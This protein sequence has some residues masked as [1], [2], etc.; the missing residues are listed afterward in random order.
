[1][2][3]AGIVVIGNEVL[4]GK[5]DEENARYL[6][7]ELR[8]LGVKLMRV[9]IVRDEVETIA[10]E[11]QLQASRFTHVFT[12]GGVGGTHDDVT[13]EGVAHAFG[14]P[15]VRNR[16]LER[17]IVAH[18]K[19]RANEMVLRM[20]DLP[21]GA[22]LFGLGTLVYPAVRVRNVFVFPGVPSYF[23][24]K[25]EHVKPM[26]KATPIFLRQILVNVGE[27]QIAEAMIEVQRELAAIEIGSYPR[28]DAAEYRVK[29][30][31]EGRDE[32]LVNAGMDRLLARFSPSWVV[33]VIV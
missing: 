1:M 32:A 19:E 21:E 17:L 14:I 15:I 20:A 30:T 18:Y 24:A 28:F 5:V 3:T 26:L 23:R 10:E 6:T 29:I 8:E 22:D 4:S 11:V 7:R 16:E 25:F 13:F 9:A 31:V 12:S 27:D 2:P 33:R